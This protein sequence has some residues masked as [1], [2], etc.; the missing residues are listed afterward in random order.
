MRRP[1]FR[2]LASRLVALGVVQMVLLA[3]T[4]VAIFI[5]EGPHEP[6]NPWERLDRATIAKLAQLADQPDALT[7]VLDDIKRDRIEVSI[8][9]DTRTL[10]ASNVDPPLAIPPR[11]HGHHGFDGPPVGSDGPVPGLDGPQVGSDGPPLGPHGPPGGSSGSIPPDHPLA[12][13]DG[14]LTGPHGP[15]FGPPLADG[16]GPHVMIVGLA[17]AGKR[18]VL[19]ARGVHGAPPGWTGP[20]LTFVCGLLVLVIG[21]LVTARWIVRPVERLTHAARA[22][23]RGDLRARSRLDRADEIGD[24]GRR[25]DEMA[26]RIQALLV[27]EKELLANVAHELRTP[28]SRIGVALDLASEGDAE[29]AR[30]S[31]AEIAVDVAELETIVDDILT[32]MRFEIGGDRASMPEL[33]MR[34]EAASPAAIATAAADRFRNR[35]AERALDVEIASELPEI[36]ADRVLLRR[37]L[38]NL[39]E[40]SHKYTPDRGASIRLRVASATDGVRFEVIDRGAGIAPEDLPR[41][42]NA[43]FRGERSRSRETGGVGLG[44]TLA[45]RIA[46]AHGGRIEIASELGAGTTV[47]VTMPALK[48]PETAQTHGGGGE[49]R[50]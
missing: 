39:L 47:A 10:V 15:P 42:F 23:G 25:F 19:I 8:Y 16:R 9:D 36:D 4:A 22:L 30:S 5:A 50:P 28:L 37:I 34:R 14:P 27:T 45:K 49:R 7:A 20:L 21:A 24:L 33:P 40:N 43:F 2:T 31:L 3:A 6:A 41:I 32:A 13:F 48:Q 17:L 38:D 1:L 12:G 46:E 11:R 26:E 44:L 35:H 18:G 29:A